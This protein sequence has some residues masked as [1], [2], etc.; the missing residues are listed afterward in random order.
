MWLADVPVGA[1]DSVGNLGTTFLLEIQ[2]DVVKPFA[3]AIEMLE[4]TLA[5][6]D[7]PG[8]KPYREF[9]SEESSRAVV[10]TSKCSAIRMTA[11]RI[12]R[13]RIHRTPYRS[14][15][16]RSAFR[17]VSAVQERL[18]FHGGFAI[19][20]V[21]VEAIA[22]GKECFHFK[23]W[24]PSKSEVNLQ[25]MTGDRLTPWSGEPTESLRRR[26]MSLPAR[27]PNTGWTTVPN[28]AIRPRAGSPTACTVLR[29]PSIQFSIRR[30]ANS[31]GMQ[32]LS[33]TR[34]CRRHYSPLVPL[35]EPLD[36][37]PLPKLAVL[38]RHV[39]DVQPAA[40]LLT[41]PDLSHRVVRQRRGVRDISS[42]CRSS[43]RF[44]PRVLVVAF[45]MAV[46]RRS[47]TSVRKRPTRTC[48]VPTFAAQR[49][50]AAGPASP[51]RVPNQQL[52]HRQSAGLVAGSPQYEQHEHDG[53]RGD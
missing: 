39:L 24:A 7:L 40:G 20:R 5:I 17:V 46:R 15:G 13:G 49:N 3:C 41:A 50:T 22:F 8:W 36:I 23:L 21:S 18:G 44:R 42:A 19:D 28:C 29:R 27:G 43:V 9:A 31:A 10:P 26:W 51:P 1:P 37:D 16:H 38:R 35:V 30:A 25:L 52:A 4:E 6:E 48:L 53:Q 11:R 34:T 32:V 33:P 12:R 47:S 2:Q 14:D 45:R